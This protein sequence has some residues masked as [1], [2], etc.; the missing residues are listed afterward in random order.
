MTTQELVERLNNMT[1]NFV[2]FSQTSNND[3]H[4]RLYFNRAEL[5]RAAA[6]RLS[7]MDAAI[8]K[9]QDHLSDY[10]ETHKT[11]DVS[12]AVA[13]EAARAAADKIRAALEPKP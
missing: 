7:E 8:R 12:I 2:E 1:A 10:I 3:M 9:I 6:S 5:S 4:R 11:V 13:Y